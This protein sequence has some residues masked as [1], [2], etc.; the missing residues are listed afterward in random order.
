MFVVPE[1]EALTAGATKKD[2]RMKREASKQERSKLD[3]RNVHSDLSP[4]QKDVLNQDKVPW[5][6]KG[7]IKNYFEAIRPPHGKP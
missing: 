3:Y 1:G 6:L 2:V 5:E 7:L 4:A